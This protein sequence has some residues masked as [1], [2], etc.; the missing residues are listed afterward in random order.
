MSIDTHT[1]EITFPMLSPREQPK[2]DYLQ[3]SQLR[4]A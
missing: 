4:D 2:S 3:K 1:T